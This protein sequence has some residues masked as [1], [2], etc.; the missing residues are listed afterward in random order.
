MEELMYEDNIMKLFG[1]GMQSLS[2]LEEM[3]VPEM[4]GRIEARLRNLEH[5]QEEQQKRLNKNKIK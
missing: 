1:D 5:Q 4:V 3:D 2:I